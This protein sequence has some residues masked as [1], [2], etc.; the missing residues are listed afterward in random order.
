MKDQKCIH[1]PPPHTLHDSIDSMVARAKRDA[2]LQAASG[3]LIVLDAEGFV[4][5]FNQQAEKQFVIPA[6]NAIG[7]HADEILNVREL[8]SSSFYEWVKLLDLDTQIAHNVVLNFDKA[9]GSME[10][11]E[12]TI[13]KAP[14][15]QVQTEQKLL[16]N[17]PQYQYICVI[18]PLRTFKDS[19]I[20]DAL[21]YLSHTLKTPLFG[22]LGLISL[23]LNENDLPKR[24]RVYLERASKSGEALSKII[25]ITLNKLQINLPDKE[26][27]YNKSTSS[28]IYKGKFSGKTSNLASWALITAN[29]LVV[30]VKNNLH[31]FA[32]YRRFQLVSLSLHYFYFP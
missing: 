24:S 26:R 11:A 10:L 2:I 19:Q 29:A 18:R 16:E 20:E 23:A 31:N 7:H 25:E 3:A 12:V 30:I 22:M 4:I 21:K 27:T 14:L 32:Y 1:L 17:P 15:E 6:K 28:L 13:G 9:D 8:S 5:S